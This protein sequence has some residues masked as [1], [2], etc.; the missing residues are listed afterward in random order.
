MEMWADDARGVLNVDLLNYVEQALYWLDREGPA[1]AVLSLQKALEGD[2]Q[3]RDRSFLL[4]AIRLIEDAESLRD[5]PDLFSKFITRARQSIRRFMMKPTDAKLLG[6]VR[7]P[8]FETSEARE[9]YRLF[10]QHEKLTY[11]TLEDLTHLSKA[12]LK[13]RL[14]ILLDLGV[15]EKV[16]TPG[17]PTEFVLVK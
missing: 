12:T 7:E 15:V 8:V 9:L 1:K 16:E 6:H 4:D 2:P 11:R 10:K 3:N 14:I 17:H 5:D 13:R